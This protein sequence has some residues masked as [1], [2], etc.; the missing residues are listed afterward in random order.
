MAGG[1]LPPTSSLRWGSEP[2]PASMPSCARSKTALT[3]PVSRNLEGAAGGEG[4]VELVEAQPER[5][6]DPIVPGAS[7][8]RC[9]TVSSD[10]TSGVAS[11]SS[12][13]CWSAARR[14]EGAVDIGGQIEVFGGAFGGGHGSAEDV[15]GDAETVP[16]R[17]VL[18]ELLETVHLRIPQLHTRFPS[19]PCRTSAYG[20][21]SLFRATLSVGCDSCSIKVLLLNR[22]N[23][24][25][26]PLGWSW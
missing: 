17:H 14:G 24:Y 21:V 25:G 1:S 7:N 20:V 4:G 22:D 23:R 8:R 2:P 16:S 10:S 18:E 11:A 12:R 19:N 9:C 3:S 6:Y 26:E 13:P 5:K 15:D